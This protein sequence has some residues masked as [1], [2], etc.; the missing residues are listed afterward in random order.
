MLG[1]QGLWAGRD[2]NR[3]TPTTTRDLGLYGLIRKTGTH[4]PQWDSNPRRK[5][6]SI[7]F[8][9]NYNMKLYTHIYTFYYAIQ[10]CHI[11]MWC[12]D[13]WDSPQSVVQYCWHIWYRT[14]HP[15]RHLVLW[16]RMWTP[17]DTLTLYR[18]RCI[19]VHQKATNMQCLY[20][21][22]R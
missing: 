11:R 3:A 15:D 10:H 19:L 8:V 9:P 12:K 14:I 6:Q 13:W 5:D 1:A 4:V 2:L 18:K 22:A 21:S 16:F 7:N 17:M 20:K